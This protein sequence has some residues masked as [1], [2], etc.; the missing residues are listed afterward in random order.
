MMADGVELHVGDMA[1]F[2]QC[3]V[4]NVKISLF[5]EIELIWVKAFAMEI[6]NRNCS[7]FD[8]EWLS[9]NAVRTQVQRWSQWWAAGV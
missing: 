4:K 7:K 9:L 8:S 2:L 1:L 5:R 6:Y 3:N